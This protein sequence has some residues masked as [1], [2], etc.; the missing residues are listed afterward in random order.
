MRIEPITYR[1]WSEAYRC[2]TSTAELI[3]VTQ[4]GPRILC[5]RWH[6]SPNLLYEDFTGFGLDDWRL[7]GGHRFTVAPEGRES[8]AADNSPCVV[9]AGP[10]ELCMLAP[11]RADGT[12]RILT[13]TAAT[14]GDGFDLRHVFKNLSALPWRGAPW[15]VT[16]VPHAGL[17]GPCDRTHVRFWPGTTPADWSLDADCIRAAP[18]KARGK[19]GWHSGEAWLAS[20]QPE[21]TLVIH[22]PEPPRSAD[23]VDDGCNLEIF[24]CPSYLEL[25]TL[26]GHAVLPPGGSA[27][28]RQRWRFLA[29]G[30]QP[31]DWAL[32]ARRAGCS[33]N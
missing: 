7:Y 11:V 27:E 25:E 2:S 31:A 23:C 16:C 12:Q 9:E 13:I 14:D 10:D 29:P 5:L 17:A 32:I 22:N 33:C 24:A 8:Y 1:H 26:G 3:V 30:L 15:T 20:L 4:I 18:R 6:E 28:L 21:A 19:I